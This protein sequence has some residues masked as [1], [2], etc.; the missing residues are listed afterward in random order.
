MDDALVRQLPAL[1]ALM[2]TLGDVLQGEGISYVTAG[3]RR[4]LMVERGEYRLIGEPAS[5]SDLRVVAAQMAAHM[6]V[7]AFN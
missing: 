7:P 1:F 3:R 4:L 2:E 6:G 5:G